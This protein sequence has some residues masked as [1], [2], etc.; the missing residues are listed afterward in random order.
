VEEWEIIE[1]FPG[2]LISDQGRVQNRY[3]GRI[4][5]HALNHGYPTVVLANDGRYLSRSIHRLVAIAFVEGGRE[6]LSVRHIDENRTN[7]FS[8]NLRW[9]T[10]E[11]SLA[12]ARRAR[13]GKK[14]RTWE[15]IDGE[16]VEIEREKD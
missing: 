10:R 11:E 14:L 7:N 4:L 9:I 8:E 6:G 2:Y 16:T 1:E 3:T 15:V 5:K 13:H 12:N